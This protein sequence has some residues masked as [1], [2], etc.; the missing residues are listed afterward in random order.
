MKENKN[1][2][3]IEEK[4]EKLKDGPIKE[5]IKKDLAKKKNIVSK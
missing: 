4:V 5:S 2:K 3:H 1:I